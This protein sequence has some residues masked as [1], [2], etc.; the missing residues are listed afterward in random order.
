MPSAPIAIPNPLPTTV[1]PPKL[2]ANTLQGD[3]GSGQTPRT[4]SKHMK[5]IIFEDV[6]FVYNFYSTRFRPRDR[7]LTGTW[8]RR[9]GLYC[10]IP[11]CTNADK[12]F[13]D[14]FPMRW[15]RDKPKESFV[16]ATESTS[17]YF[18]NMSHMHILEM[19]FRCHICFFNRKDN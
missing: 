14:T 12:Q 6:L 2:S 4:E 10:P 11:I 9:E 13:L 3:L 1:P 18:Y 17:R 7:S 8:T 19:T 15:I 5:R 16:Q